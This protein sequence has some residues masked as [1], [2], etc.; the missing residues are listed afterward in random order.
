MSAYELKSPSIGR[1]NRLSCCA[2]ADVDP[3]E[4]LTDVMPRLAR[5]I[6]PRDVA[7]LLPKKWK[8]AR[9]AAQATS[10]SPATS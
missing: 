6:R 8:A 2:L 9:E 7:D 4:Y 3:V 10:A 5:G 1:T